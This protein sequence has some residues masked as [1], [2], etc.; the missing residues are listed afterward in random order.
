M[1][2]DFEYA[3][4]IIDM[5]SAIQAISPKGHIEE[6]RNHAG[7]GKDDFKIASPEFSGTLAAVDGSNAMVA[8][9]GSFA[10]AAARSALAGYEGGRRA[11]RSTSG[12]RIVRIGPSPV[13]EAYEQLYLDCFGFPPDAVLET[14]D[15]ARAAAVFRDTLEYFTAFSAIDRLGEGDVLLL[16]G[17]LRVGH[18]SHF[19][20][21]VRLLQHAGMQGV[22]VAAVAKSTSATWGGGRPLV[23]TVAMLAREM[24][25]GEPWYLRVPVEVLDHQPHREWQRGSLFV[26]RLHARA[27]RA[28]KV[29][30]PGGIDDEW[31][32]RIFAA[33]GAYAD[34]G[35]VPGY[36]FP[37]LEAHRTSAIREDT[38]EQVQQDIMKGMNRLDLAWHDYHELFGDYHDELDRY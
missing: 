5:V 21:M 3:Q 10:V 33:C 30:I 24:G 18:G 19:P 38:V 22:A 35:R 6:F 15:R 11:F 23:P 13:S 37:L 36:P 32:E 31:V 12:L 20:V 16:D 1:M 4:D 2:R 17:S 29:E 7:I 8:E 34:D 14:E 9:S 26:S 28:F 27:P 25:I